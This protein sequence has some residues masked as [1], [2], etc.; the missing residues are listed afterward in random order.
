MCGSSRVESSSKH[1][2]S[3]SSAL[4]RLGACKFEATTRLL[5]SHL[6]VKASHLEW[7]ES[8]CR[9]TGVDGPT[10]WN[11]VAVGEKSRLAPGIFLGEGSQSLR[12]I[13]GAT[14][15]AWI[16]GQMQP[17]ASPPGTQLFFR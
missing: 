14:T 9:P 12:A 11:R 1:D 16:D 15:P 7:P 8:R 13:P 6:T 10:D 17:E 2:A 4:G 5:D 3:Q